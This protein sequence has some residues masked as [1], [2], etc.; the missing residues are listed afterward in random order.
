MI[1]CTQINSFII[2]DDYPPGVL[3]LPN[4]VTAGGLSIDN[5]ASLTVLS[6]PQ[7]SGV[8]DQ[9]GSVGE[10]NLHGQS[11]TTLNLPALIEVGGGGITIDCPSLNNWT[12]TDSLQSTY[13]LQILRHNINS[14]SFANLN[15]VT[16]PIFINMSSS[17]DF[18]HP[19]TLYLNGKATVDA[20]I[21]GSNY[22]NFTSDMENIKSM[23][24]RGCEDITINSRIMGSLEISLN[25]HLVNVNA[26]NL[27]TLGPYVNF[28]TDHS[29]PGEN[30]AVGDSL[31]IADNT[32]DSVLFDQML[33][34]NLATIQGSLQTM[35]NTLLPLL[36]NSFPLLQNV[37]KDILI[38]GNSEV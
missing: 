31:L 10:I 35:G 22:T 14:L 6:L 12:G 1:D 36:T 20:L 11:L 27:L 18:W 34:P 28:A 21:I 24:V 8:I 37:T 23:V 25:P 29:L 30:P 13:E 17:N 16:W 9:N 5:A 32:F 7:L 15:N 26:P 38:S 33:F 4:L 19:D 2:I 3:T